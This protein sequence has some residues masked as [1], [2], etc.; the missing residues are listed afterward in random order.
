MKIPLVKNTV[1][2]Y[3][4]MLV[5]LAQGILV[6]RW[7]IGSLGTEYYGLWALLW[8]FFCYSLL[9]DFGLGAAAQKSTSTQL[10]RTDLDRYNRLISTIFIFHMMMASVILIGTGIGAYFIEFLLSLEDTPPEKLAYIRWCFLLFGA[11]SALI[12]PFGMFQEI[13]VGLQQLYWRNYLSI[14]A[15]LVELA[16]ILVIFACHGGMA[17]LIVFT[18]ALTALTQLAMW[19]CVRRLVPGMRIRLVFDRGLCREIFNFS[20]FVYLTS[21]ARLLWARSSPL[22]IGIFCGLNAN[23][24]YQIGGRLPTLMGQF[25][26]PY[27][28]NV[29]PLSAMLHAKNKHRHLAEILLKSM[30]WNSFLATGMSVGILFFVEP[31]M[32]LLFNVD[33]PEAVLIC[34]IMV[35]S[36]YLGLVFRA[37]PEKYLLMADQ[38]RF[39]S[40]VV[41]IECVVFITLS[42]VGLWRFGLTA[43]VVS[44]LAVKF[45]GTFFFILP[46]MRRRTGIA[47]PALL[48]NTVWRPLAAALP[49]T[50]FLYWEKAYWG[51]GF[52]D[53][54]LL[55]IAAAGGGIL[56]GVCSLYWLVPPKGRLKI[57]AVIRNTVN[58]TKHKEG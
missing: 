56:Y 39:L 20:G 43:V 32:R 50:A 22:L 29:A 58:L 18:L 4:N 36:I 53:L 21:M 45:G 49:M 35:L 17:T 5:K 30:R 52:S 7:L 2:N 26:S 48:S 24:V 33:M 10:W 3:L 8:A 11:G 46:R 40:W 16:G 14:G 12:F 6:T 9:L 31:L 44:A 27:Q 13:L 42:I 51:S 15:K 57:F 25:T 37:I 23:A 41:I 47:L 19:F 28:E 55:L 38:H 1:T 34:R 54:A